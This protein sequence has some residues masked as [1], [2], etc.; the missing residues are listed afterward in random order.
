MFWTA[1]ETSVSLF[2]SCSCGVKHTVSLFFFYIWY[3]QAHREL[4]F[5]TEAWNIDKI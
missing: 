3:S 1:Y 5:L 2:L 4:L